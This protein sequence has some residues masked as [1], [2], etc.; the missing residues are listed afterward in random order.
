MPASLYSWY[1][2]R[3]LGAL[4]ERGGVVGGEIELNRFNRLTELLQSDKGTVKATLRFRQDPGG[5][6]IIDVEYETTV[7]L[8]CQRCLEPLEYPLRDRVEMVLLESASLEKHVPDRYEP[9]VLDDERLM[10]AILIEDELIISLP[11]VPR[12]ERPEDCGGAGAGPIAAD[13]LG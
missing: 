4:G 13:E 7:Q 6:L 10:P 5:W 9:L 1:G 8:L 11:I 12:H 2:A 3:E